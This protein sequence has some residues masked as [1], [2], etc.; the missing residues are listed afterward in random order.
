MTVH[1]TDRKSTSPEPSSPATA[2]QQEMS[3]D[4]LIYLIDFCSANGCGEIA[5][6]H[7]NGDAHRDFMSAIIYT[8]KRGLNVCVTVS[9]DLPE[10][11]TQNLH[12]EI[13]RCGVGNSIR[14]IYR[15]N[16]LMKNSPPAMAFFFRSFTDKISLEYLFRQR[17]EDLSPLFDLI[18]R[19]KLRREIKIH[20][21]PESNVT[22]DRPHISGAE[23]RQSAE[24]IGDWI[25][26]CISAGVIPIFDRSLPMC[27]FSDELLGKCCRAGAAFSWRAA[28]DIEV[29][30]E[31]S[32]RTRNLSALQGHSSLLRF[33]TMAELENYCIELMNKRK[34]SDSCGQ[35]SLPAQELCSPA[36]Y[37]L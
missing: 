14:F 29:F 9:S 15:I 32:V 18:A 5:Y 33:N 37:S 27:A 26:R 22:E 7:D 1:L 36:L 3:W 11:L 20:F 34:I 30:P 23:L 6:A 2:S 17:V 8:A 4:D 25:P 19:Y 21:A 10:R 28:P 35:C 31:L 16:G 13:E 24:S 12:E